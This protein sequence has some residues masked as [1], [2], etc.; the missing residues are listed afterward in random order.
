MLKDENGLF[1][2]IILWDNIYN[3]KKALKILMNYTIAHKVFSYIKNDSVQINY[4][5]I[6]S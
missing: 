4:F 1:C 5:E 2:D 6:L 3:A